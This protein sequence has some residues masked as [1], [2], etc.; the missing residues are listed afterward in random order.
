MHQSVP[1][2]AGRE[3]FRVVQAYFLVVYAREAG[4]VVDLHD[5]RS[6]QLLSRYLRWPLLFYA[7][8]IQ[9]PWLAFATPL[10]AAVAA[11]SHSERQMM[12]LWA[13]PQARCWMCRWRRH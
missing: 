7:A 11:R 4:R 12:R 5:N 2:V 3:Q 1:R 8:C 10:P 6:G 13:Q 9:T